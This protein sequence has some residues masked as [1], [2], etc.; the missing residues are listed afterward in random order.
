MTKTDL[1][2]LMATV[3][4]R[5][6]DIKWE[7]DGFAYYP[8]ERLKEL[9]W[10]LSLLEEYYEK[11]SPDFLI[12]GHSTETDTSYSYSWWCKWCGGL[13]WEGPM[14]C[15]QCGTEFVNPRKWAPRDIWDLI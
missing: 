12:P 8:K 10:F 15:P 14:R 3:K 7:R 2:D 11:E 9:D 4:K 5:R 1:S 6:D 13:S